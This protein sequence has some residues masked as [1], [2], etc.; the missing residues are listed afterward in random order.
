MENIVD[1][2]DNF[3]NKIQKETKKR[4]YLDMIFFVNE[5]EYK[6]IKDIFMSSA[7]N[8]KLVIKRT[9]AHSDPDT[10]YEAYRFKKRWIKLGFRVDTS[11]GENNE[12]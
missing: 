10:R 1:I 9:M 8:K 2:I 11:S 4:P 3:L 6:K 5:K 12:N 7:N